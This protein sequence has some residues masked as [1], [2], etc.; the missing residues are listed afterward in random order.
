MHVNIQTKK[1][2][3]YYIMDLEDL[4]RKVSKNAE[5]SSGIEKETEES[6]GINAITKVKSSD[7]NIGAK[8]DALMDE[9]KD[10]RK[11]MIA[12]MNFGFTSLNR[13]LSGSN[14]VKKNV[15]R[16]CQAH[17]GMGV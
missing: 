13:A 9:M 4:D 8:I 6:S 10:M 2:G 14:L 17:G 11:E 5:C 15:Y 7:D 1:N 16:Y 3:I 12:R